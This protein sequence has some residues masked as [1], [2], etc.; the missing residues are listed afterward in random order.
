MSGCQRPC[1]SPSVG[2]T[3]VCDALIRYPDV[4]TAGSERMKNST[5]A[6]QFCGSIIV[7]RSSFA[8]SH[9]AYVLHG[10]VILKPPLFIM[11]KYHG[12]FHRQASLRYLIV[13]PSLNTLIAYVKSHSV[14]VWTCVL[15][16]SS[17]LEKHTSVSQSCIGKSKHRQLFSVPLSAH[18]FI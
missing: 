2:A 18:C 9:P 12:A 13:T 1:Y 5:A 4:V 16:H 10:C 15:L 11:L 8:L 14:E 3:P 17:C 7:S 6:S